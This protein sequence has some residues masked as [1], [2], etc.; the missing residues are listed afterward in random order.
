VHDEYRSYG[1]PGRPA[2]I[3]TAT[4]GNK[5]S[6]ALHQEA[7]QACDPQTM[8]WHRAELVARLKQAGL[9]L[10]CAVPARLMGRR[11]PA[12]NGVVVSADDHRVLSTGAN[13]GES[14]SYGSA[15]PSL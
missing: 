4:C 9:L 5:L 2:V 15:Y 10:G 1:T 8:A 14:R 6:R 13:A 7:F 11:K 12:P 3:S